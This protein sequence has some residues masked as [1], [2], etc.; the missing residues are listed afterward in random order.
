MI[1][2][3]LPYTKCRTWS[4]R[5]KTWHE[6][7]PTN[8]EFKKNFSK[9]RA[10]LGITLK[11][12]EWYSRECDQGS[13]KNKQSAII[14]EIF[15]QV[16]NHKKMC[17][18]GAAV[19]PKTDQHQSDDNCLKRLEMTVIYFWTSYLTWYSIAAFS[20]CCG[21]DDC[22]TIGLNDAWCGTWKSVTQ[23]KLKW[24]IIIPC[25]LATVRLATLGDRFEGK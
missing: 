4:I 14:D 11:L 1:F 24:K 3:L 9:V 2:L 6:A 16:L 13:E 17:Q 10:H 12:P 15:L 23:R 21:C 20:W 18:W 8:W 22:S 5:N 25:M 19:V 7:P